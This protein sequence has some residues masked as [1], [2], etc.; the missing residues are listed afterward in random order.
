VVVSCVCVCV[1]VCVLIK[2]K[3]YWDLGHPIYIYKSDQTKNKQ[4][5]INILMGKKPLILFY[6]F[7]PDGSHMLVSEIKP[8]K[9]K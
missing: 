5:K 8:C 9:C 7:D 6:P 4:K 3:I 2:K 1:C